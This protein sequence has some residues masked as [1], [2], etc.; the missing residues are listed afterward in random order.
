[1]TVA[2]LATDF[3]SALSEAGSLS[4]ALSKEEAPSLAH[5]NLTSPQ[6]NPRDT[7]SMGESIGSQLF[8]INTYK[9]QIPG[10]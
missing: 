4:P 7:A 5:E 6:T 10:N 2:T 3:V 1:V 8:M 9:V